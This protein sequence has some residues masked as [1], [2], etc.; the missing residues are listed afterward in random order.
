MNNDISSSVLIIID[1]F[2]YEWLPQ[3]TNVQVLGKRLALDRRS[4]RELM[5]CSRTAKGK[6]GSKAT[7][8][9]FRRRFGSDAFKTFLGENKNK[10]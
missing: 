1:L 9:G 7:A 4:L 10:R 6:A 3:V 5:S 8:C 2:Y